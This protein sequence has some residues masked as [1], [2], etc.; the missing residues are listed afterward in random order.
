MFSTPSSADTEPKY[1]HPLLTGR[2]CRPPA[3]YSVYRDRR[4]TQHLS[5]ANEPDPRDPCR[6]SGP[7][8]IIKNHG[9]HAIVAGDLSTQIHGELH[10]TARHILRGNLSVEF[11]K[12]RKDFPYLQG[13]R[14][15]TV[16]SEL[17][18][19]GVRPHQNL[20]HTRGSAIADS[21]QCVDVCFARPLRRQRR[22]VQRLPRRARLQLQTKKQAM[23]L[24]KLLRPT[25]SRGSPLQAAKN[26]L[27]YLDKSSDSVCGVGMANAQRSVK[28]LAL[29]KSRISS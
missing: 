11:C 27:Q 18:N 13:R 10:I 28:C 12:L 24:R 14:A 26:T 7:P 4:E 22:S 21:V 29:P 3:R 25:M 9:R 5:C 17:T 19:G 16:Q 15:R 6:V 23:V 2:A 1:T 8:Q 20:Q